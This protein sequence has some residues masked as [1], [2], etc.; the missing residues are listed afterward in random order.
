MSKV[1]L[2]HLAVLVVSALIASVSLAGW[3]AL[4]GG[5]TREATDPQSFL[6][7]ITA[8]VSPSGSA[9]GVGVVPDLELTVLEPYREEWGD[10]LRLRA[11]VGRAPVVVNFWAS[12]CVPCRREAPL[13]EAAWRKYRGRI[14]FVGI[15]LRDQEAAALEF[16]REFGLTFPTGADPTGAAANAFGLVGL[17]TTYFVDPGGRI[18]A[19]KVGELTE[20]V[21]D[22]H[23]QAL[24]SAP[25]P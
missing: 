8:S 25:T 17:P 3:L 19:A 21:L 7:G 1:R 15:D 14:Q 16:T 10:T 18:R 4:R 5:V 11:F 13:L 23:L 22:S 9:A 2:A 20:D 6:G 24:L 12:W